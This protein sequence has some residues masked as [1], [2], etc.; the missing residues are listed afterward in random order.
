[1]NVGKIV[2]GMALGALGA[3]IVKEFVTAANLSGSAGTIAGLFTFVLVG[4]V[5]LYALGA[6]GGK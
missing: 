3:V 1:M 5:A 6:F 2:S 4:A